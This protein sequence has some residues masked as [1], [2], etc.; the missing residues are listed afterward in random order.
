MKNYKITL[1]GCD[2]Y[3]EFNMDLTEDEVKLVQRICE[4]SK[5][6]SDYACMPIMTCEE[7]D[8]DI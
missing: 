5:G 3:T 2:D 4:L 8:Y 6:A 7:V 1:M